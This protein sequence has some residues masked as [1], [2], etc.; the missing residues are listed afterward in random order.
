MNA[1]DL[2]GALMNS[3]MSR[4]GGQRIKHSMG[5][6]G[7]GASALNSGWLTWRDHPAA[8]IETI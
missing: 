2:L 4:S 6:G 5:S 8:G 7:M 1:M 3:G